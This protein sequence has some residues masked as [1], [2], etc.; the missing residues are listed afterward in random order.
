MRVTHAP[1]KYADFEGLRERAVALR[2]AGHSLR[3]IRDELKIYNNDILNQLVKGEPPPAWTKRPNAKDDLRARARE[4]RLQGWT[5]DQIQAELS[6][7]K[8]SVSLW[9]RDLPSPK[10]SS[11]PDTTAARRGVKRAVKNR[12]AAREELRSSA[13]S[14]IGPLTSRE[15]FLVG[16]GLYWSEGAKAK[17][18][19]H[20]RVIFV[21]SDPNMVKVFLLWLDLLDVE[22]HRRRFSVNIHESA[23]IPKAEAFWADQVGIEVS[24]LLK[25]S[26]KKH[27]PKTNRTNTGEGY[28]GCLRVAVLGSADLHR[29]I[30]GWWYGIVGAVLPGDLS[31][32]T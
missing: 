21:N 28:Y 3:Q 12:A 29:R 27:N 19:A 23:D 4:L 14:E 6:C 10:R 30:E 8:S 16:V 32:R 31:N 5:Y 17:K 26:L 1:G 11:R 2:R 15:L 9:V 20:R 25:T 24:D 18:G 7:S 22:P 13:E